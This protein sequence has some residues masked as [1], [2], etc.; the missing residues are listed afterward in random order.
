[1]SNSWIGVDF[2]QERHKLDCWLSPAYPRSEPSQQPV[3]DRQPE[4]SMDFSFGSKPKA[5][6]KKTASKT[7]KA[8][9]RISTG[10]QFRDANGKFDRSAWSKDKAAKRRA[11]G[12]P[13]FANKEQLMGIPAGLPL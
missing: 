3:T 11:A 2:D 7:L 1:M 10:D 6:K 12:V 8:A 13:L 5:P 4:S 9:K